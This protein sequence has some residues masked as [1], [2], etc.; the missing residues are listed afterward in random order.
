MPWMYY[1]LKKY[2]NNFIAKSNKH[3]SYTNTYVQIKVLRIYV[4]L[5]SILDLLGHSIFDVTN[6]N[7]FF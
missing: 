4:N 2:S 7:K 3:L 5:L 1:L 6:A